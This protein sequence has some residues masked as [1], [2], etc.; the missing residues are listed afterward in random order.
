MK[1][2]ISLFIFFYISQIGLSQKLENGLYI[3][4]KQ[5]ILVKEY[6]I[7]YVADSL[8]YLETYVRW[9][10]QW[11]PTNRRG[12]SP[13]QPE[14]LVLEDS[15]YLND[16]ATIYRNKNNW[17]CKVKKTFTG[18]VKIKLIP[19]KELP[20]NYKKIRTE[21]IRFSNPESK[22]YEEIESVEFLYWI[23]NL[24]QI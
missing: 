7:I 13:Y 16:F 10:G 19:V 1:Y 2:I 9:Q 4:E 5:G 8:L 12:H 17:I 3:G 21:A 23:E 6:G 20:E 14:K 18:K 15:Q 24:K 22:K 11:M